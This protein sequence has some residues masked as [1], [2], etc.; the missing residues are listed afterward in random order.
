MT[1]GL[2]RRIVQYGVAVLASGTALLVQRVLISYIG[3]GLP[4]YLLFYPAVML[5]ATVCGLGPGLLATAVSALF[6]AYFILPPE[7]LA[8]GSPVALLGLVVFAWM[9]TGMS[10]MAAWYRRARAR[11]ARAALHLAGSAE[12]EATP[13]R[14]PH[15]RGG[16]PGALPRRVPLRRWLALLVL[17]TAGP[18]LVFGVIVLGW[19]VGGYRADQDRRQTDTTRALAAA[20]DAEIRA[21]KTA[22]QVLAESN[23]LQ[24]GRLAAFDEEAR[25]VAARH[26]GWIVLTDASGQQRLNTRRAFGDL[27]P[28]TGTPDLIQTVFRT[29][30]P[31]VTDLVF[32]AVAQRYIVAVVVPVI[33]E[34]QVLYALDMAF[35][36]ERL[37]RL[38][39]DQ[40]FP[41]TWILGIT[42][43][44]QRVVARVPD[45]ADRRGQPAAPPQA[46]A[47][48][49]Q[50][51]G[52]L[53]ATLSDGRVARIAFQRLREAPWTVSVAVPVAELQATWQRPVLAFLLLG[54]LAALGAIGLAARLAR[55]I[56]DPMTE[57]ARL[58]VTVVQGQPPTL[59]P[60]GIAEVAALQDALADGA[61]TVR[62]A[63]EAREE[64]LTALREANEGLERANQLL[65]MLSACNEA[66]VR[67]DDEPRLMQEICR[68]AVEIGGYRMAWVGVADTDADRSVRP[69]ASTGF[70]AGYLEAARISWAD[71]ERGRGPTGTA[72]RLGQL[73][74]GTDFLTEPRL[75]PWREEALNR[76]FR[77]SIALPLRQGETVFG[78][79][80]IYAA[81]P[82]AFGDAQVP[83]LRELADDLAFGLHA[84]RVRTALRESHDRVRA[85]AGELT[86][87][88]QRER[89]R[90]ADVLH[91]GLQ[92]QLVAA[93]LRAHML[94]RSPVAAVHAGADELVALLE[95]ALAQTRSLAGEL[96]P[97]A[98]QQGHLLPALEWLAGWI[99]EKHRL[100]VHV[101]LAATPLAALPAAVAVLLYQS[102]RELL[103]NAVK[104]A[105]VTT[106]E[107]TLTQDAERFT[108]T[109]ADAGVGFDPTALRVAGGTAGGVGLLGIRERLEL[110]GGRLEIVSARGQGSGV[111]VIVP[112]LP[113]PERAP[114]V[115]PPGSL[116][117]VAGARPSAERRTRVLVVDDHAL[118]RRGVA[119]LLAGEPDLEVVGEADDGPRAIELTRQ[120]TPDVI[121][122]DINMP[123]LDG[124]EATRIIHAE[125]PAVRVI[126]LS[127]FEDPDQPAAMQE[128]G[129]V[130]YFSKSD[131]AE[132]LLAAIRGA[133]RRWR[134]RP[135]LA[136]KVEGRRPYGSNHRRPGG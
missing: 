28:R 57:A 93:R 74:I 81:E 62:T 21:W 26:E 58:A 123:G 12:D 23:D 108:C 87:A 64:A 128:A 66:L 79:L 88:E 73:Q 122:M 117:A 116:P 44:R 55:R 97:P 115:Q 42:D 22:L 24:H 52:T 46:R 47:F 59:A 32:G 65:R 31:L 4:T 9:G 125:F 114:A 110:L 72:I 133:G 96:N 13:H 5:T 82:A 15:Q 16:T 104:Y 100:T 118:V 35:D 113:A 25:A 30:Q 45:R 124:I 135:L 41:A 119:T 37:T 34:G 103:L 53:D 56:A 49:E 131:S 51:S 94:A 95:E 107:V 101:R 33:R 8:V 27:L 63:M 91:D 2:K 83:V 29:R 86:L 106:A 111:T 70:E 84:V 120:L 98:L 105:Q 121:L 1:S 102:V 67:I 39:A 134:R 71:T 40:R 68:I 75:A 69:V 3:P 112:L 85:L 18:L 127:M 136:K 60:S 129:A 80:T 43:G 78:V 11:A 61:T 92:Q 54:G 130:G 109:V 36:P 132:A 48:A 50:P 89:R 99:L 38:L 7:G 90:L 20:V 17:G 126:G 77:S 6:A 14:T 19:L 10:L 76:G